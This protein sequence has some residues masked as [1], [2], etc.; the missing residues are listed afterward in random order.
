MS[1][2]WII[3]GTEFIQR[4]V[5]FRVN[6]PTEEL[7]IEAADDIT[8]ARARRSKGT[9]HLAVDWAECVGEEKSKFEGLTSPS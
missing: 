5:Q 4:D 7:A 3:H 8:T 1:K 9:G 2:K 6:A